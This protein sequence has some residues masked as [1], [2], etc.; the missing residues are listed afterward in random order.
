MAE[1]THVDLRRSRVIAAI[2][3][4]AVVGSLLLVNVLGPLIFLPPDLGVRDAGV[5]ELVALPESLTLPRF[6]WILVAFGVIVL[7]LYGLLTGVRRSVPTRQG[8][9]SVFVLGWCCTALAIF[10]GGYFAM[11]AARPLWPGLEFSSQAIGYLLPTSGTWALAFGWIGGLGAAKAH[12]S[13]AQSWRPVIAPVGRKALVAAGLAGGVFAVL[14]AVFGSIGH[15]RLGTDLRG[16]F[17]F[18]DPVSMSAPG[19]S[20][21][22]LALLV[23]IGLVAM[24]LVLGLTLRRSGVGGAFV[25]GWGCAV[26]VAGGVGIVRNMAVLIWE[27]VKGEKDAPFFWTQLG[28]GA[29]FGLLTGWLVGAVAAVVM[30]RK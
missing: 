30:A 18:P 15:E 13:T 27:L 8:G 10:A 11:C 28:D 26:L 29:A 19:I 5:G 3:T 16:M 25:L 24:G 12:S 17:M 14:L 20:F 21:V 4:G 6:L 1:F 22:L 9:F 23:I 2:A 7:V